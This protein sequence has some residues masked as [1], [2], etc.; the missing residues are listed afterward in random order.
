MTYDKVTLEAVRQENDL[1]LAALYIDNVVAPQAIAFHVAGI[2]ERVTVAPVARE[3][4][5]LADFQEHADPRFEARRPGLGIR[6]GADDAVSL[7]ELG[8]AQFRL[9]GVALHRLVL[10]QDACDFRR[11]QI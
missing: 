2:D 5:P 7:A 4:V 11:L 10:P 9:V 8:V 3:P 1:A 6:G